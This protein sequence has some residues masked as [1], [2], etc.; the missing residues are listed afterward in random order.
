VP[1]SLLAVVGSPYARR[2]VLYEAVVAGTTEDRLVVVADT[3][4]LN[5]SFDGREI[6]RAWRDD[7]VAAAS[8]YGR[9]GLIEFRSDVAG[10]LTDEALAAVVPLGV[11]ELA[12]D[13]SGRRL[14]VAAF[15][16]AT[17]SGEDAAGLGI[18]FAAT[19]QRPVELAAVR[20]WPPPFSPETVGREVATLAKSY[21]V[22]TIRID[23]YA[24]GLVAALFREHGLS[25][26]VADADTSQ[27]FI[28]L[29]GLVNSGRVRLLDDPALLG[30]LRR[31]E[32]RAGGGGRE[33]V[34]HPPRGH[35]DLA[36][37]AA[38]ALVGAAPGSRKVITSATWGDGSRTP[39]A[40]P[41]YPLDK[42]LWHH[43]GVRMGTH[44]GPTHTRGDQHAERIVSG[45]IP[46]AQAKAEQEATNRMNNLMWLGGGRRGHG[47]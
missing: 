22:R 8:E 36:A 39:A 25:C 15:D 9:N 29:L 7:P 37:A 17:G 35:D 1:G 41:A 26:A 40:A 11:R 45:E 2:G 14:V 5:P 30:E 13:Q 33:H 16:A 47:R 38:S 20:R 6:A 46:F 19:L 10:L 3:A 24:P 43:V 42:T 34:G 32:R 28:E 23:R 44:H 4:T 18:A 12:P 21:G 31:L 27:H